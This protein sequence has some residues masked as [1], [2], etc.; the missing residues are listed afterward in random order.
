VVKINPLAQGV[1]KIKVKLIEYDNFVFPGCNVQKSYNIDSLQ[2]TVVT[3][4]GIDENRKS[5]NN[6]RF[7]PNPAKNKIL[8]DAENPDLERAKITIYNSIGQSVFSMD[9]LKS[10]QEINLTGLEAGLYYLK[11]QKDS[12]QKNTKLFKE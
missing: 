7:Y 3:F 11:I 9:N 2:I 6:I 8:I 1:Y 12:Y 10:N 4:T 5:I